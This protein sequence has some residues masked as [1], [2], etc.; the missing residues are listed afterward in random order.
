M[1]WQLRSFLLLW[2]VVMG[3]SSV[4]SAADNILDVIGATFKI[5]NRTSN[6]TCFVVAR[7]VASDTRGRE[8]ILV[9]AAHVF[10]KMSGDECRLVLREKRADGTFARTEVPLKIRAE[11]KPL[12]VKHP[13]VDVAALKL[14]LPVGK[15]ISALDLDQIAAESTI[16]GGGLR[17]A[18]EVWILCY[19]AQLEANGAGFPII[20][21]GTV[22][23]F[24]LMPINRNK[25][26]LVDYSSFGGD[27]GG[28]VVA[29]NHKQR[30][31]LV[32]LVHGQHRET[33]KTTSPTEERTVHR[34]L[35]LGII[36]H[37][38]FIRQTIDRIPK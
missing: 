10:E 1:S 36:L 25:T 33:T 2:C 34:S 4:A 27:S 35:G 26:F 17:A 8:L 5:A 15:K 37:A 11:K 22:A 6:A 14:A 9:T 29:G 16:R 19:P 13:E 12:W 31:L 38:E 28:P 20:R 21:R 32:G 23:S 18:D 24:P 30:A 7:P 3:V